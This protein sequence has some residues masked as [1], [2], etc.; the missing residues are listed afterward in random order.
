MQERGLTPDLQGAPVGRFGVCANPAMAAKGNKDLMCKADPVSKAV[1]RKTGPALLF[2]GL[3]FV[4]PVPATAQQTGGPQAGAQQPAPHRT[5]PQQASAP[6]A[7][8]SEASI[9]ALRNVA[10]KMLADATSSPKVQSRSDALSALSLLGSDARAVR[11]V[12]SE[13][14]DSDDGNRTQAVTALGHMRARGAIPKLRRTMTEDPSPVVSFAAAE[15]LWELGDRSGREILYGVLTGQQKATDGVIKR[16]IDK[17]KKEIHDPKALA[18]IG[19]KEASGAFLGPFAMGVSLAEEYATDTS[20][21]VQA[22]CASLLAAD[23]TS[24]T[25]EQLAGALDVKSWAVRVAAV[26]ALVKMNRREVIPK[27]RQM[28]AIDKEEPVRLVAAAAILKLSQTRREIAPS[29]HAPNK[30]ARSGQPG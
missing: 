9:E 2:V 15:A 24:N 26:R 17:A 27:L 28:M 3:I 10:W 8:T 13:L 7:V 20:A 1:I 30:V 5:A 6:E 14:D 12:E 4:M 11:T 25:A 29:E 19:A 22:R 16:R 21:P 23:N 18:L